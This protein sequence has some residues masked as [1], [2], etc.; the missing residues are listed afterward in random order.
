MTNSSSVKVLI[1]GG[2][3]GGLSVASR[4]S[5][6]LSSNSIA[7]IEPSKDH[8][9][10]PLW[11]LAGAGVVKKETTRKDQASLIP[12]GV[13][14]IQNSVASIDPD[15]KSV[16]L[17]NGQ[18]ISYE[19]LVV[20]TGLRI[21]WEAIEGLK[22]NLGRNGICSIY[23]YDQVDATSKFIR[24]FRGGRAYFTMPPVPIKCAG[25][26]QKIMYLA[27]N[28]F[29]NNKVRA[30]SDVYFATAG[31]AMFGVPVF[32][33]A[34]DA[35]VA[36]RQIQPLF[37]HR[38]ISVNANE[39]EASFETTA[40]DGTKSVIVK[41][42]DLLHV[43][44]PMKAHDFIANSELAAKEGDQKGWLE[45]NKHSL[46][47]T[48]YKN[49]FGVGDVTGVPN[50]KTGAAIRKQAPIVVENLMSVIAGQE[51]KASYDGYSSCPLITEIGKVMLAEFGYDGKLMPTFPVDATVPRRSMWQLK[52][53]L[54]PKL[55]WHGMLKGRA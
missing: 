26:P 48:K 4:L 10:Q 37:S 32:S 8:F 16:T 27:E 15:Q 44:P 34:L 31:K 40:A 25:A 52:K 47:H 9:Y 36:A 33:K 28:I 30:K 13:K 11:T 23:D 22:G 1:L 14:W 49:V 7:I 24:E 54:L 35:I 29:R 17:D 20:A 3:S 6:K 12:R 21:A 55:Y 38:L 2:G 53:N 39:Q 50:S 46:Q 18:T 51:P 43:V 19:F 42:F 41:K 45:V 5:K